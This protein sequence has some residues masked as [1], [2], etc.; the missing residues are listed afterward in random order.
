MGVD[1]EKTKNIIDIIRGMSSAE[2]AVLITFVVS[3]VVGTIYAYSWIEG[4]YVKVVDM[5]IKLDNQ[6]QKIDR[7]QQDLD[8]QQAKLR[9]VQANV[10][11]VVN[12]LPPNLRR[13]ITERAHA[14]QVLNADPDKFV[15]PK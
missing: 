11:S 4:R 1:V 5:Q 12:S 3:T 15:Q 14:A 6:Q 9:S 8:Q 13:E 10:I 7:Q 2:L